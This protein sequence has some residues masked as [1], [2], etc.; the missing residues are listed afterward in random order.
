[1]K[2][3]QDGL[4]N[5]WEQD[6]NKGPI[7]KT[8]ISIILMC[9]FSIFSQYLFAEKIFFEAE[10]MSVTETQKWQVVNHFDGWY[11]GF[12]S[13][14]KMLRGSIGGPAKARKTIKIEQPG[15]YKIWVRY[16]DVLPYRGPFKIDV[17]QDNKTK[18]EKTFDTESLRNT[19][20]G[21][22]KWGDAFGQFVWDWLD[23]N[24]EKGEIEILI[25][26]VEPPGGASWVT[27]HLDLIVLCNEKDY[28]PVIS[29]FTEQLYLKIRLGKSHKY[30][31]V[32]HVFGRKP[33][34]PWW[35]P[36]ANIYKT[37]L[38]SGCYTG[39]KPEGENPDF[40]RSGDESPWINITSFFD[41]MGDHRLELTAMQEYYTGVESSDFTVFLSDKPSDD[42]IFKT[43]TRSGKGSGM[44]LLIDLSRRNDIISD[45]EGSRESY[46][47]AKKLQ[48]VPGKRPEKFPVITGCGVG[49]SF[50]QPETVNNEIYILSKL[51]FNGIG[52]YDEA[53]F[54]ANFT[55]IIGGAIYF[56]FAKNGC[57]SDP[58][59]QAIKSTVVST[60]DEFVKKDL[61][62]NMVAWSEMDEPGSVSMEH[63]TGCNVCQIGFKSYLKKIG[64]KPEMF[65]V[66]TLDEVL[67]SNDP[68]DGKR[69]YYT[70]LYRNQVLS[71]FF[72]IGTDILKAYISDPRTTANF[73][74]Y[75]TFTGNMLHSGDDWFLIFNNGGLTYGW[76]EDWLNL[77]A[78]YQLCGYRADF[79]RSASKGK[80]G[81]YTIFRNAW[82]TQAKVA[83]EIGHGAKAIYYYNYGPY[84]AGIDA[85]SKNYTLYPAVQKINHS[86][87][88]VED[89]LTG[90]S[91]PKSSV[92]LLY[93]HTTDI[94]TLKQNT[95]VFGKERMGLWLILKHL[96]YSTDIIT[97]QDVID[98]KMRDYKVIFVVGS[99]LPIEVIQ[100]LSE[101]SRNGGILVIGPGT[102]IYD[103]FNN[104]LN[105]DTYLGIKREE[106]VFKN[107]PGNEYYTLP[108]LNLLDSISLKDSTK[109]ETM[110]VLCGYQ[111]MK[112]VSISEVLG[113]FSDGSPAIILKNSGRGKI[114][115]FGFFPG[116]AYMKSAVV[117]NKQRPQDASFSDTPFVYPEIF[118]DVFGR[119]MKSVQCEAPILC[120]NYLVE[121]NILETSNVFIITLSNWSGKPVNNLRVVINKTFRGKP[122]SNQNSL[123]SF[124]KKGNQTI[125]NLNLSGAFDF[126]GIPK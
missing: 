45:L 25:T 57:L 93:S 86:I 103:R 107:E 43:F 91:I 104:P 24:L 2:I 80:F 126:I 53:Y 69:Y 116:I 11:Y 100:T 60:A 50:Y 74:E 97:E 112:N 52:G 70:V 115:C 101:W 89:Y 5:C 36:H 37:G 63:I 82:D 121:P 39:Y 62:K 54:N 73:G 44:I 76:T 35:I 92:A 59:M 14:G 117:A 114:I 64:L 48:D 123:I 8:K 42:G 27:R 20:E 61:F 109:H 31:C 3:F 105:S 102:G 67:P 81:M 32:I 71:D 46:L 113:S 56:H 7:M 10:D 19:D 30:P 55:K 38:I 96:G 106:F 99:H 120:D 34:P 4:N 77:S 66:K 18:A 83:S 23:A 125:L 84:Y 9:M 1:M 6:F 16:L 98:K 22:K 87:G 88:E 13:K 111:K 17:I 28:E 51:G 85:H 75:L 58:D 41:V 118:R 21:K 79:L 15:Q 40:L 68:K 78:S 26:K 49:S 29:D 33:Q 47:V 122:F 108:T 72:K 90:A 95:S 119:I 94:W 110:E 124:E 65:D 12:P